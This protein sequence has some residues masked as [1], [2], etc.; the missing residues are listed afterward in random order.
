MDPSWSKPSWTA[1]AG[2]TSTS[3]RAP[4]VPLGSGPKHR[5]PAG[6]RCRAPDDDVPAGA[7]ALPCTTTRPS[8]ARAPA[9]TRARSCC[10]WTSL[11]GVFS[12]PGPPDGDLVGR[13]RHDSRARRR[14]RPGRRRRRL[15]AGRRA[16]R[17]APAPGREPAPRRRGLAAGNPAE[18]RRLRPA[19]PVLG[20]QPGR[21]P[22]RGRRRAPP[23]RTGRPGELVLDGLTISNGLGWSPDG[24][25]HVPRRQRPPRDPRVRVRRR[26][27]HDLRRASHRHACRGGRGARRPDGGR[28]RRPVG[29]GL[30]RRLRPSP[31]TGRRAPPRCSRCPAEQTTCCA[32][33]GPGLSPCT[34]R[35]PPSTGATSGAVPSPG[36]ASST[37]SPPTP[38][39]CPRRP[40]GRIP[41]GGRVRAPD[42]PTPA[43]ADG[44]RPRRPPARAS[45]RA[46]RSPTGGPG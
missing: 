18:R 5:L 40:S 24:A 14:D 25:H 26:A 34:S 28:G 1:S 30:R 23:P 43:L 11:A 46:S 21:R 42:G 39:A 4:H 44:G 16:R 7:A 37:G 19:G 12:R 31:R 8:S 3:H 2:P 38:S 35:P 36:P 32:F 20:R 33:G 29:R 27:R 17:R 13:R 41:A 15:A 10:G 45:P 6:R 9:G 22:P